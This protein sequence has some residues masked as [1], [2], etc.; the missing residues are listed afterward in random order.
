VRVKSPSGER[1]PMQP[2]SCPRRRSVTK[3]A[4]ACPN[5]SARSDPSRGGGS[6]RKCASSARRASPRRSRRA[7]SDRKGEVTAG[8]PRTMTGA[9]R[10][11]RWVPLGGKTGAVG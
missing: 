5:D 11:T 1:V 8:R 6:P 7:D 4:R 9:P 10:R 2:R 3:R